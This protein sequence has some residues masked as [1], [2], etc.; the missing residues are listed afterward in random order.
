MHTGFKIA[1]TILLAAVLA[2]PAQAVFL[3][4]T[5][6]PEMVTGAFALQVRA[7]GRA[8]DNVYLNSELDYRD[9]RNLSIAITPLAKLDLEK[10]YGQPPDQFFIGKDIVVHGAARRMKII[11][12]ADGQPTD[13]YYYQTHVVVYDA[14]QITIAEPSQPK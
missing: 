2:G 5:A 1:G 12:L 14:S 7:A 4:A 3:A 11:F 8:E 6:A 9:Q 10:R 13:K